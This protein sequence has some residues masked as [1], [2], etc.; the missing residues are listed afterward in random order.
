LEKDHWECTCKREGQTIRKF[1]LREILKRCL[2]HL[3]KENLFENLRKKKEEWNMPP[4]G[5]LEEGGVSS[6][7]FPDRRQTKKLHMKRAD[8]EQSTE[9]RKKHTLLGSLLQK[10]VDRKRKRS[11]EK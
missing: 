11:R 2:L 10:G 1:N 7:I 3:E 5:S 6:A 8:I 4:G 9:K